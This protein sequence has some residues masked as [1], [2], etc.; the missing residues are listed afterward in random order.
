VSRFRCRCRVLRL[1]GGGGLADTHTAAGEGDAF[2]LLTGVDGLGPR[3]RTTLAAS[4]G[5]RSP[6][7]PCCYYSSIRVFALAP[8]WFLS[9]LSHNFSLFEG[10]VDLERGV[11]VSCLALL[12]QKT[13][14]GFILLLRVL[15][16]GLRL[17]H[18]PFSFCLIY[19]Q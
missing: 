16:S 13:H 17:F 3:L 1:A 10:G 14:A 7:A 19:A 8:S 18:A 4:S 2:S 11:L 9:R 5:G 12:F 15:L 6:P